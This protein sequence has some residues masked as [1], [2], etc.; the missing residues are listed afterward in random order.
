LK[1]NQAAA[2]IIGFNRPELLNNL[3]NKT[4]FGSRRVYISIDAPR[5]ANDIFHVNACKEIAI[6]FKA[7]RFKFDTH[8]N[9]RSNN[10]GLKYAVVSAIDWAF[11]REEKLI[12][13][14][15]D[16]FPSKDFFIYMDHYLNLFERDRIIWQVGGHNPNPRTKI[17]EQPYLSVIPMIWGWGTWR[18]RW[19]VYEPS[20]NSLDSFSTVNLDGYIPNQILDAQFCEYW[21]NR[22]SRIKNGFDTWDTQWGIYMWLEKAFSIQPNVNLTLNKG[23]GFNST[24]TNSSTVFNV[25]EKFT[26][27]KISLTTKNIT[28]NDWQD[29][30]S[31]KYVFGRSYGM[32]IKWRMYIKINKK[33]I[34][35]KLYLKVF[36][37]NIIK[38][39]A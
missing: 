34:K 27:P 15:D 6:R 25:K 21:E 11:E 29:I 17:I 32:S 24:N 10:N 30:V 3:L 22:I 37:Y 23:I 8:L 14:E 12:I 36:I 4:E 35:T 2:L 20:L 19:Q 9:F 7:R 5:N 28:R 13:L 18:D 16:I 31:W 1:N 38:N 26:R 39:K 33:F